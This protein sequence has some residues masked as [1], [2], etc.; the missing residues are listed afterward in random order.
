[1]PN[2]PTTGALLRIAR[3]DP[4]T[5][6]RFAE[7]RANLDVLGTVTENGQPIEGGSEGAYEVPAGEVDGV[8]D[9]FTFSAPPKLVFRNG[10]MEMRKGTVEGNDFVFDAAPVEG[11]DIEGLI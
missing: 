5:G 2:K 4:D 10:V 3:Q 1:M 6:E 11:D 7:I 8:N 9:T